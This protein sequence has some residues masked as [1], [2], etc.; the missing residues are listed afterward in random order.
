[1]VT[2]WWDGLSSISAKS[3]PI[4]N[5]KGGGDPLDRSKCKE[6]AVQQKFRDQANL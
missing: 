1:M 4:K 2:G 3:S 6:L 5:A